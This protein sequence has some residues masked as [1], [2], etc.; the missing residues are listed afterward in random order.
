M[1]SV[2][3]CDADQ[4]SAKH[5]IKRQEMGNL[6]KPFLDL[7]FGPNLDALFHKAEKLSNTLGQ[8][9][10]QLDLLLQTHRNKQRANFLQTR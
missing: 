2:G 6:V 9:H 3:D 5:L 10:W 4:V 7:G 1:T 8:A